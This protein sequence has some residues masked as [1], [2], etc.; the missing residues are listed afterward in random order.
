MPVHL[1]AQFSLFLINVNDIP[2]D[3]FS[4]TVGDSQSADDLGF[5]TF[6]KNEKKTIKYRLA[7]ILSDFEA[8]CSKW[9]IKLNAKKTQLI[10]LKSKII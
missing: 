3:P 9:R 5:W 4:N 1:R 2:I 6:A 10:M 7:K 8:W